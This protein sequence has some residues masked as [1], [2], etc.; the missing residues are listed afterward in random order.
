MSKKRPDRKKEKPVKPETRKKRGKLNEPEEGVTST[1][2]RSKSDVVEATQVPDYGRPRMGRAT[3]PPELNDPVQRAEWEL[4]TN[5][6]DVGPYMIELNLFY[7]AGLEKGAKKFKVLFNKVVTDDRKPT[8]ISKTYFKCMMSVSE[9]RELVRLD[10][11]NED[12][13]KR[14]IY[15]IWPD[16][17]IKPLIDRSVATVKADAAVRSYDATGEGIIWAVIDSGIDKNHLH[18]GQKEKNPHFNTLLHAEVAGLHR[19]FTGDG[20]PI[21]GAALVDDYG[22]GTHVAGIIAGGLQEGLESGKDFQAYA[23][24]FKS[25]PSGQKVEEK[26]KR[27]EISNSARL[28]GVAPQCKLISL[29]VLNEKG[30]GRSSDVMRAPAICER[31]AQRGS[32]IASCSRRKSEYRL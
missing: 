27:R 14:V 13:R 10:E 15:R 9:W 8:L 6:T 7:H 25:D 1:K 29:K 2:D 30:K 26:I 21:I 24:E 3:V 20:E 28:R 23:K 11:M 12:R 18:F 16:Y 17:P 32:E 5:D 19:D 4:P 31:R 22:H